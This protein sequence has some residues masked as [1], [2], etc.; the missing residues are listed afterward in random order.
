MLSLSSVSLLHWHISSR[1]LHFRERRSSDS[2]KCE[3]QAQQEI[4]KGCA[5]RG[6]GKFL[7]FADCEFQV[8]GAEFLPSGMAL[9]EGSDAGAQGKSLAVS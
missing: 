5:F 6:N 1:A 2:A 3:G 9:R 4:K 7:K 8:S